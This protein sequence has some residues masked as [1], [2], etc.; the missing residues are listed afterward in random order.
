M[1][2]RYVPI[3]I[4]GNVKLIGLVE[5]RRIAI[6]GADHDVENLAFAD[7][8]PIHL[9]ILACGA[10]TALR[11]CVVAQELLGGEIDKTRIGFELRELS[12]EVLQPPQRQRDRAA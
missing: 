6:G 12:R 4:A 8:S 1:A 9:E 10:D 3:R 2:E 7:S 11:R 5:L